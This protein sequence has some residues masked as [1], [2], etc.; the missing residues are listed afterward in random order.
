MF[1]LSVAQWLESDYLRGIAT[2]VSYAYH[3]P[4][5]D[6]PDLYQEV[7]LALW[8]AGPDRKVNATWVF[9][10]ANHLAARLLQRNRRATGT[11][12]MDRTP[13][14]RDP[15]LALLVRARVDRLPEPLRTFYQLRYEEGLSQ[16]EIA[17]APRP[18]FLRPERR[19]IEP[20]R[21]S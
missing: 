13:T 3:L 11:N 21:R 18:K 5:Q 6:A 10:T 7:C 15:E 16:G 12:R 9:H 4:A 19:L 20:A 8:K 14:A 2:R 17:G 1:E